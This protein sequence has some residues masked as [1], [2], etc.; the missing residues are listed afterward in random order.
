MKNVIDIQKYKDEI[1][2][3]EI[4]KSTRLGDKL[5]FDLMDIEPKGT[6]NTAILFSAWTTV[7]TQLMLRGWSAAELK[8]EITTYNKIANKIKK[9]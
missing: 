8:K 4:D 2:K 1:E 9:G 7:A 6:D 5:A 3:A